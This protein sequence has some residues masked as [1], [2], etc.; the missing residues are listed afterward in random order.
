MSNRSYS[1]KIKKALF[2]RSLG[3]C[4]CC[5]TDI[6]PDNHHILELSKK[7]PSTIQNLIALCQTCHNQIPKILNREQ[8]N[9][10]QKWHI[11]DLKLN[12]THHI[13][14]AHN[15][16]RLGGTIYRN[17]N[18]ILQVGDIPVIR[19]YERNGH[20]YINLIMLK[21]FYPQMLLLSNRV[22]YGNGIKLIDSYKNL[23]LIWNNIEVLSLEQTD[24]LTCRLQFSY[25]M[26]DY[27]FGDVTKILGATIEN[28]IFDS[29]GTAIKLE[30]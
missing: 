19:M 24:I 28:G 2:E 8:Q 10:L 22:I 11:E 7:G 23:K 4:E 6:R 26:R 18:T 3:Y 17:C 16:I 30:E 14:S 25:Y 1:E 13:D 9:Y 29:C 15:E 5:G 27:I 20:Y 12:H 21:E